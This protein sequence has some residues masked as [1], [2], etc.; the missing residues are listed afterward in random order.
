MK[1]SNDTI[2]KL[3][4]TTFIISCFLNSLFKPGTSLSIILNLYLENLKP[5]IQIAKEGSLAFLIIPPLLS[6]FDK[7]RKLINKYILFT[8]FILFTFLIISFFSNLDSFNLNYYFFFWRW[9]W[10]IILSMVYLRSDLFFRN[11]N[12]ILRLII[13]VLIVF[14]IFTLENILTDSCGSYRCSSIY[15]NPTTLGINSLCCIL[16]SYKLLGEYI[17]R[18]KSFFI[19]FQL[20]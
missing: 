13:F 10:P 2:F 19:L 15:T 9:I 16:I 20:S 8:T 6:L 18:K 5:F 11:K 7:K 4:I 12:F 17:H 14:S 3:I 1:I